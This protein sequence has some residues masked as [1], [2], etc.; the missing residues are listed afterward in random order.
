MTCRLTAI[1]ILLTLIPFVSGAAVN[2]VPV[3]EADKI[4]ISVGEAQINVV[5]NPQ[6]KSFRLTL[7]EGAQEEFTIERRDRQLRVVLKDQ[8]SREDLAKFSD[9][10]R[11]I[12]LVGPAVPL[13]IHLFEGQVVLTKWTKDALVHVQKG[14]VILKDNS[15]LVTAHVQKGEIQ[16]L[17]HQGKLT[18]DSYSANAVIKNLNGDLSLENFSGDSVIEK[19]KGAFSLNQSQG[20]LKIT[21]SSGSMNFEIGKAQL[22]SSGFAGRIE[23]QTQDGPVTI[24]LGP[25]SEVRVSSQSGRV[26]V[27]GGGQ[28]AYVNVASVEGDVF[29]PNY[30]KV[31]RDTTGKSLR[32]RLR[33]DSQKGSISVRSQEGAIFIK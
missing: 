2:E 1:S 6:A 31:S 19:A 32:G 18:I 9:K 30:L 12:E 25:E 23:G 33:G 20:S 21:G 5:T 17:D 7:S 22:T 3:T 28:G 29:A 16:A 15:G 27:S 11:S 4:I 14:K 8:G 26:T 24:T 10:K 13:E